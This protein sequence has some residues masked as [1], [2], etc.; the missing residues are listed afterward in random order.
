LRRVRREDAL[1]L[2][3]VI[4]ATGRSFE[5]FALAHSEDPVV[6]DLFTW[7][8]AS[9]RAGA[10]RIEAPRARSESRET[11][12]PR[13]VADVFHARFDLDAVVRAL[14]TRTPLPE[15]GEPRPYAVV[16][17]STVMPGV[18]TLRI[19]AGVST[20]LEHLE[21]ELASTEARTLG[22]LRASRPG[23]AATLERLVDA[24]LVVLELARPET[25]RNSDAR[26]V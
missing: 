3:K 6:S 17:S 15:P 26:T 10:R 1:A 25:E 2:V 12:V 11:L 8:R 14:I 16:P 18:R 22:A 19:G 9:V 23:F 21:R 4:D 7:E 20:A 5:A 24:G 13:C